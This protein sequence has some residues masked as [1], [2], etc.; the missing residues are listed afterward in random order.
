MLLALIA[1]THIRN[2]TP[3]L[4]KRCLD[5]VAGCDLVV[6]GTIVRDSIVPYAT[7]RKIGWTDV[8][9]LGSAASYDM[10]VAAA[11]GGVRSSSIELSGLREFAQGGIQNNFR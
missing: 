9:F 8:D 6:L 7:A 1:D 10:F 3:L 4:P 2:G 5:L 11:Q